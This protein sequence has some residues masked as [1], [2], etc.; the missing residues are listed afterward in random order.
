[1]LPRFRCLLLTLVATPLLSNPASAATGV[2]NG[3]PSPL[4]AGHLVVARADRLRDEG[5]KPLALVKAAPAAFQQAVKIDQAAVVKLNVRH[6]GNYT[7]WIRAGYLGRQSASPAT[8]SLAHAGKT[9]AEG[10]LLKASG[11]AGAGGPAGYA[12]FAQKVRKVTER[13]TSIPATPQRSKLAD[14]AAEFQEELLRD[15][16]PKQAARERWQGLMRLEDVQPD[17]PFYWWKIGSAKLTPGEHELRFHPAAGGGPAPLVDIAFLTTATELEYPFVGDVAAAPAS[18]VRFRLASLPADGVKI[19]ASLRIHSAPW[20]T[21]RVW[22]NPTGV[23]QKTGQPHTQAGFTRWYRLQDIEAVPGFGSATAHLRISLSSPVAA[24][25]DLDGATQFA[26]YPHGDFFLREIPWSEPGGLE[27]S[28]ATDFATHLHRLRTVRDQAREDYQRA[29]E[30]TGDRLFPLTRKGLYLGNAWGRAGGEAHD[31]MLQTF[32]LLGFNCVDNAQD[33]IQSRQLYGWTSHAGHYWPP[34]DLPWDEAATRVR[35]D[36]HYRNYF[37]KRR[38]F[39]QGVTVFQVADEPQEMLREEMSA[40]RWEFTED[41]A[42]GR[43]T[44]VTGRSVLGTRRVDYSDC[45]LEGKLARLGPWIGLQVATDDPTRPTRYAGWRLGKV[46][47]D[48]ADNLA[49]VRKGIAKPGNQVTSR[50][51]T[52]GTEPTAFKIVYRGTSAALYVGGKLLHQHTDLPPSGGF[53]IFG[54]TKAI[55]ELRLRAPA[56]D[57]QIE[58][59]LPKV[60]SPLD[61]P[62]PAADRLDVEKLLADAKSTG[63]RFVEKPLERFV[64]EDWVES[65][66][67]PAAHEGFRSWARQ[68]GL[69][70]ESFGKPDWQQVKLL[71]VPELV[72]SAAT[73]RLYYWSRRYSGQLTPRMF[74]L[75]TESIARNA[76][77][78]EMLGF[79]ALSGH[80]LYFPSRMPLDMFALADGPAS[81]LPGVSDWMSFGGWRWDSH[82]A[83]AYSVAMYNAGARRYDGRPPKTFPMMHCVWPSTLRSYTMLANQVRYL[84]YYN[85]GPEYAVTEG[86]W[87]HMPS[88]YRTVHRTNNR[89]AQVDDLLVD[90]RMRPSRVALLY[91]RSTEYWDPTSSFADRRAT[92]LALAHEY[93]QPELVTEEQIAAGALQHY[94]ALLVLDPYVAADVQQRIAAWAHSGGLLWTCADALRF[95]EYRRQSDLL[96]KVAGVRRDFEDRGAGQ[97]QLL[98]GQG[99]WKFAPHRVSTQGIPSKIRSDSAQVLAAYDDG[100]PA[101]LHARYGDG[102]VY[103]LGHRAGLTY[104]SHAQRPPGRPTAWSDL[105]RALLVRPLQQAEVKR[106][107]ALSVPLVMASPLE[108]SGGTVVLLHNMRPEPCKDV[109]VMLLQPQPPHRVEAFAGNDLKALKWEYHNGKLRIELPELV[110]EQMIVVRRQPA[111]VDN[112]ME[113]IARRTEV[114]L[115]SNHPKT[116][117]AGCWFAGLLRDVQ[118]IDRLAELAQHDQWTVRRAAVEALGRIGHADSAEAIARVLQSETD[119]HVLSDALL[120]A[121]RIPGAP[122]GPACQKALAHPCPLVRQHAVRAAIQWQQRHPGETIDRIATDALL[123]QARAT[124]A[125]DP[126]RRIRQYATEAPQAQ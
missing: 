89:V 46:A 54:P 18:Y 74:Q 16:N 69:T 52:V 38:D 27:I 49:L 91:A 62:S 70:P 108:S 5:G 50:K 96:Q 80:A 39:Y 92:F 113:Q 106:Q 32:R 6:P 2:W 120:A 4:D 97:L 26:V 60:A 122:L 29:V 30:V 126:D 25:G 36:E 12:A 1:M 65:G 94:D 51:T 28:L 9:L 119:T 116:L 118:Q 82:Q 109:E 85:F 64:R 98:S 17:A 68:Q 73:A 22:L 20:Q 34:S 11:V 101:L 83:V 107:L 93:Y 37:A 84:S 87:S 45:V 33:P 55:T 117:T 99:K 125:A 123:R 43:W 23:G 8:V 58:A 47:Y 71:T 81:L 14:A 67:Y 21:P 3:D 100:S 105:G 61:A 90:S 63:P 88:A 124:A 19:G 10:T 7:I 110:A 35:Y 41:Q 31:Y 115:A 95:D 79:V 114:Q 72:T 13:D 59:S 121:A 76:P 112:R 78:P 56:D 48:P 24:G 15:L 57:E 75:A 53:A 66:G 44:D 111:P 86:Y 40:P 104:T 77:N 42:P 103:Y 102:E